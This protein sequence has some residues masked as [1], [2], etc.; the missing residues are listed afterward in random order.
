LLIA[1]ASRLVR[2][3]RRETESPATARRFGF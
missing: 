3:R 2:A 1:S